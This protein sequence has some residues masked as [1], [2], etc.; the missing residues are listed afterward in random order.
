M[1][2]RVKWLDRNLLFCSIGCLLAWLS[3]FD[4]L[5]NS[6]PKSHA[7]CNRQ[8]ALQV[9]TSAARLWLFG[10]DRIN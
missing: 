10:M 8:P 4:S 9:K 5:L 1:M 7:L 6:I 2:Q 3:G